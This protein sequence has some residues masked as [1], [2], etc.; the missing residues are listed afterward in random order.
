M[1]YKYLVK[2]VFFQNSLE[3]KLLRDAS[4]RGALTSEGQGRQRFF[5][6]NFNIRTVITTNIAL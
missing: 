4:A 3:V 5:K 6:G 1:T 2:N